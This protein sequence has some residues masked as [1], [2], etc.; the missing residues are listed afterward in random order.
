[1]ALALIALV[2]VIAPL[3]LVPGVIRQ[4][5]GRLVVEIDHVAEVDGRPRHRLVLAELPVGGVQVGKVEVAERRDFAGKR[6]RVV[7]RRRDE[8]VEVD[9]LDVER[10]AHM[11]AA[12]S[13]QPGDLL[14]VARAV[15]LGFQFVRRGRHLTERQGGAEDLDE[16][17]FHPL[18]SICLRY[19]RPSQAEPPQAR[20][21]PW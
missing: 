14:L 10:L 7:Q 6:R 5:A 16:E 4:V 19:L 21:R 9:V 2:A 3:L 8:L 20:H 11:G 13:Q 12:G 18:P 15:E 17:R 1:M